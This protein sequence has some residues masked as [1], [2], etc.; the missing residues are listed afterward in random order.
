MKPFM[1]KSLARVFLALLLAA[2]G[3]AIKADQPSRPAETVKLAAPGA[4]N[5]VEGEATL[6]NDPLNKDAIGSVELRPGQV[7]STGNDGKVEVLLVPGVFLRLGDNSSAQMHSTSPPDVEVTRGQATVEVVPEKPGVV[8]VRSNGATTRLVKN[9]LYEF[10]AERGQIYVY[11]GQAQVQAGDQSVK[12]KGGRVLD[13]NKSGRLEAS[14]FDKKR[15]ESSELVQF[16]GLRSEYL[17][18]ANAD[19][20]HT[21]YMNST[22]WYGPGW[23]WSPAFWTYTWLPGA[24]YCYD[25][26]GWGF[27]SPAY[28]L[29]SPFLYGG[30]FGDFGLV[31]FGHNRFGRHRLPDSFSASHWHGQTG[32]TAPAAIAGRAGGIAPS[33]TPAFNHAANTSAFSHSAFNHSGF[34]RGS[35]G[36]GT[37]G[38]GGMR[39]GAAPAMRSGGMSSGGFGGAHVG[40]GFGGA[41]R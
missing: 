36:G 38:G 29:Y 24:D 25:P 9:G 1:W 30:F 39:G 31:S 17:A 33:P 2:P 8:L 12:V 15:F 16:S 26:F 23:Y 32:V 20:A 21:Y 6:G 40:G 3:W 34:N 13:L 5:Y 27:Y 7:V 41:H 10:D 35:V 37:L 14:K 18:E 22:G 4:V 28:A 19:A 11:K